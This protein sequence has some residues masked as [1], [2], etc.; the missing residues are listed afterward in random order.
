MK[1]LY[2]YV[3]ILTAVLIGGSVI[4]YRKA[5][6]SPNKISD[7]TLANIEALAV[8]PTEGGGTNIPCSKQTGEY[9]Y[10]R[11]WDADGK[12]V[13]SNTWKDYVYTSTDPTH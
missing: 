9:C 6:N 1:K 12:F 4:L 5:N 10:F 13:S 7:L 11:I 2:P 8:L 3:C